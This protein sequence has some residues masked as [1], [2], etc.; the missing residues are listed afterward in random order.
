[1]T[2]AERIKL[3]IGSASTIPS[4]EDIGLLDPIWEHVVPLVV[5]EDVLGT[6]TF[7]APGMA[8]TAAH[9][10]DQL[11]QRERPLA[12]GELKYSSTS[13]PARNVPSGSLAD[14]WRTYLGRPLSEE[15][16]YRAIRHN[17]T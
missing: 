8:L 2:V 13:L 10:L 6:A 17:L 7:I 1:M 9:V 14:V 4:S 3:L 12:P 11:S 16:R 15:Q 5:D